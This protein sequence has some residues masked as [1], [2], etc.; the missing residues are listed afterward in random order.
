RRRRRRRKKKAGPSFAQRR[1]GLAMDADRVPCCFL[2]PEDVAGVVAGSGPQ[3]SGACVEVLPD[4]ETPPVLSDRIVS[5]FG[6]PAQQ[7]AECKRIVQIVHRSQEVAE[8]AVGI[9][10]MLVPAAS[11]GYI[12]GP[13]GATISALVDGSGAEVS[14]SRA[15][16]AGTE[17]QPVSVTGDL[18][19][20]VDAACRLTGLLQ[21]LA[22]RGRLDAELWQP[23]PPLAAAG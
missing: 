18:S 21:E 17:L 9:F 2:V 14:I 7:E 15:P 16:V 20:T 10:V 19:Q 8:G 1:R 5:V 13:K 11:T 3:A 23:R 6:G 4:E 22:A 12:V